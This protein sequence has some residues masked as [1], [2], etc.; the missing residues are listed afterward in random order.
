MRDL[1]SKII[2]LVVIG[3]GLSGL[4]FIDTYLQ[5]KKIVHLISPENQNNQ[6]Q[7]HKNNKQ[8][9]ILPAQMRGKINDVENYFKSNNLILD[10]N[11]KVLG[12]L[13]KGGLSNFWGL[14]IDNYYN[15]Y[16]KYLNKIN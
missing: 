12:V 14:Q 4:N 16:Q 1:E 7:N 3:S 15:K 10:Q 13:N 9:K 6:N 11:S 5:K 8:K 2:D